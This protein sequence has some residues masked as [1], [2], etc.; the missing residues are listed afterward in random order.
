MRS[1]YWKQ[2]VRELD[3][4]VALLKSHDNPH[5][6]GLMYVRV[7]T[8]SWLSQKTPSYLVGVLQGT[9]AHAMIIV[10]GTSFWEPLWNEVRR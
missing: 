10:L 2:C 6:P 8:V 7:C 5:G 9:T 3:E 1:C 4:R